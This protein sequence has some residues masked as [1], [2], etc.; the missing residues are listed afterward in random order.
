MAHPARTRALGYLGGVGVGD[1]RSPSQ[2]EQARRMTPRQRERL[3]DLQTRPDRSTAEE[4]EFRALSWFTDFADPG[5]GWR[6]ATEDARVDLPINWTANRALMADTRRWSDADV[7]AKAG[8]LTMPCW[9]VHGDRDP[10]PTGTVADLAAAIPRSEL[11]VI[12]GAGHQPWRERPDD[13]QTL[14]RRLIS[15]G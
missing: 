6:W 4:V 11:H 13:L 10:R 14:L 7:L 3:A 8:R 2:R 5:D 12:A 15:V 9:F 1:W